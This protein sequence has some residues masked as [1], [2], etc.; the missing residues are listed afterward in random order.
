MVALSL[1]RVFFHPVVKM[2]DDLPGGLLSH[3]APDDPGFQLV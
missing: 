3:A 1:S 2:L